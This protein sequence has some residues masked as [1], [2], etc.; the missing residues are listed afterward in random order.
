MSLTKVSTFEKANADASVIKNSFST[1]LSFS[2]NEQDRT[3]IHEGTF[4]MNVNLDPM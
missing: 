2:V 4:M 3:S 1:D